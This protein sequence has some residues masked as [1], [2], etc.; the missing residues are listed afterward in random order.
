M[1]VRAMEFAENSFE[2]VIDKG[3]F[4]S[5]V[6]H[7]DLASAAKALIPTQLKCSLKYI[8]F[9]DQTVSI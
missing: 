8:E 4:D 2:A 3:T 9:W 6:V 7:I 1:D 5:V